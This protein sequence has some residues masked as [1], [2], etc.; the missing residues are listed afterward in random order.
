MNKIIC[1]VIGWIA[2]SYMMYNYLY[3]Y[4]VSQYVNGKSEND[5]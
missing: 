1:F 3:R 2:G 4:I 5:D